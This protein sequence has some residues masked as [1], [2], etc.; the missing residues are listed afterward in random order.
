MRVQ[1][2]AASLEEPEAYFVSD[3]DGVWPN[4]PEDIVLYG[5]EELGL[6]ITRDDYDTCGEKIPTL[7]GFNPDV[8]AELEEARRHWDI[9]CT[10]WMPE[11]SLMPDAELTIAALV[12]LRGRLAQEGVRLV[13][14]LWTSRRDTYH[15]VTDAWRQ[16]YLGEV[17]KAVRYSVDWSRPDAHKESK[18]DS[19]CRLPFRPS[20][21][22]EDEPK[23]L[24]P[25]A[26]RY[27]EMC[28]VL[29]GASD[30]NKVVE[31]PDNV[32]KITNHKD[33]A[34]HIS[35]LDLHVFREVA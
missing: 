14:D 18:V 7:W 11:L 4:T 9:F 10:T 15:G 12:D 6:N 21:Y 29:F 32:I 1:S 13:S 24:V 28:A 8:Q 5:R 22:I 17:F 2:A 30:K 3:I 16:K 26:E 20:I 25:V 34:V 31:A 35:N 33:L 23:H 19:L 27:P